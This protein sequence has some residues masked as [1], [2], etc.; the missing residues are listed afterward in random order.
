MAGKPRFGLIGAGS[1]ATAKI[2]PGL[3]E[4]GMTPARISSGVRPLRR[5]RPPAVRLRVG[6]RRDPRR[7]ST[8]A[9]ST[10]SSIATPHNLHAGLVAEALR[11]DL[12]VYVEKPLALDWE[13]LALVREALADSQAP[14]FVGFN[15]RYSPAAAELRGLPGPRLMAFRVNA[16]ALPPEHWTNDLEVGGGRLKGEGC[17]FVDFL[18]DQ[19]GSDPLT[20]TAAG[21]PSAP[22][23]A[24][25]AT[26]NF[27]LQIRFADGSV[28][29]VNYAADA[30][31]GPGKERF[32]TS[33]P[34]AYA[35][36]EDFREAAIWRGSKRAAV[37]GR[38][39]D[40]G[41]DG[42]F[43]AIAAVLAGREAPPSPEG[44]LL[45]TMATL[46]AARSLET[47]AAGDGRRRPPA[48][49]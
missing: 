2:I 20:V 10:S 35:V 17:H 45:S 49:R 40:K 11:R 39:Q 41:F 24:R 9:T 43:G 8:R 37:G 7:C 31:T 46:A 22:A 3:I 1:F 25:A 38:R 26:D 16:G 48:T 15:R 12:A 32:E 23:L 33:S 29:T 21:F 6:R 44:Y 14:L 36:I 13:G 4:A 47:G 42:Q 27:S 28:G 5:E 19:A 34:D 30:V 18:C